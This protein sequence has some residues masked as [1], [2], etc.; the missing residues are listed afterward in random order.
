MKVQFVICFGQTLMTDVDGEFPQ[1][2]QVILL[3]KTYQNSLTMQTHCQELHVLIN[4]SWVDL[5]GLMIG[6]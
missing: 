5:T 2:E 6:M 1:E 4:S 3:V